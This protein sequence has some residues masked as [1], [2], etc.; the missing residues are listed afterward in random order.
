VYGTVEQPTKNKTNKNMLENLPTVNDLLNLY[1]LFF[2]YVILFKFSSL[3][4]M[5]F[6]I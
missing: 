2:E 6:V 5:Y 4:L 1:S 3:L